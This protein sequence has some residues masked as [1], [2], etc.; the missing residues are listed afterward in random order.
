[1]MLGMTTTD[2]AEA[3]TAA[4]AQRYYD[5]GREAFRRGD[6]DECRRLSELAI[7]TGKAAVSPREQALGHIGLCRA[8]F[9]DADYD[10]G[11]ENARLADELARQAGADDVRMV[12]LHMRAEMTRAQG[13]YAAAVPLYER[14]LEIDTESGDT[15]SLAMEH[16]NLGS[17]LLQTG[18][19]PRAHEQLDAALRMSDSGDAHEDHFMYVLLGY[20]GLLARSGHAD[21]AATLLGAVQASLE[22]A[23]KVLDPA[24]ALE[25]ETHIAAAKAHDPAYDEH[26]AAGR[27]L[28]LH[29][30]RAQI[31][32]R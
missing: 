23:G 27:S 12:A 18:D 15:Q 20:A 25:Y 4:R 22:G 19:V 7:A 5:D 8:D 13:D 11:L 26:F 6:N 31:P 21:V 3:P 9:R 14:L 10:S 29:R 32:A 16:Y 28:T 1:M 17:V 2:S 24:E 30:A